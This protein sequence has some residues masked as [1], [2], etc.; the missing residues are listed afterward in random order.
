LKFE[1]EKWFDINMIYVIIDIF[2]NT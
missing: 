1:F 2:Y